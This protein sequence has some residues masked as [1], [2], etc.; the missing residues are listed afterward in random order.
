MSGKA[1][2]AVID[3]SGTLSLGAVLFSRPEHLASALRKTGLAEAGVTTEAF[4]SE[5]INPGWQKGCTTA[6]GYSRLLE[7]G[8]R[9]IAASRG[10]LLKPEQVRIAATRFTAAYL[11]RS[12]IAAQWSP[13]LYKLAGIEMV[14]IATDHYAE[15]TDH[16][17]EDL[18]M[19]GLDAAPAL[20]TQPGQI[21][22]ANSADFGNLKES[23]EF[24]AKLKNAAGNPKIDR[25]ALVDD[26]G[27]N[28][29][30]ADSYGTAEKVAARRLATVSAIESIWQ[31]PAALFPFFLPR[32]KDYPALVAE[33]GR[34]L[35]TK[36]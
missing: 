9:R 5:I 31:A 17:V 2:L 7:E 18:S 35:L 36:R 30:P 25:V 26:F 1:G 4:W 33:A 12:R 20:R 6:L 13:I 8:V 10:V 34:F 3:F 24:W 15:A 23:P 16:I 28:E 27:F 32:L 11:R 19:L 22:V 29:Q 14:V 21:I